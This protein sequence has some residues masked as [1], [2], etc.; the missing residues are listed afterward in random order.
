[1]I[2][3]FPSLIVLVFQEPF[4]VTNEMHL[5]HFIK[6]SLATI[7]STYYKDESLQFRKFL[8]NISSIHL[9]INQQ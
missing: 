6:E 7:V 8:L 4:N 1:M 9:S 3:A 5:V 2:D